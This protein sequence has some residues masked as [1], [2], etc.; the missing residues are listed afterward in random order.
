[1]IVS[2]ASNMFKTYCSEDQALPACL[3]ACLPPYLAFVNTFVRPQHGVKKLP[4]S[5]FFFP[6]RTIFFS[7]GMNEVFLWQVLFHSSPLFLGTLPSLPFPSAD[8]VDSVLSVTI[9][10]QDPRGGALSPL[11][12][13]QRNGESGGHTQKRGEGAQN[14]FFAACRPSL[15]LARTNDKRTERL[16]DWPLSGLLWPCLRIHSPKRSVSVCLSTFGKW[17]ND[18]DFSIFPR[19]PKSSS[20]SSPKRSCT[21][22]AA[23]KAEM[24]PRRGGRR[25]RKEGRRKA[26]NGIGEVSF[27]FVGS[28]R[29]LN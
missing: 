22:A 24:D 12:D 8:R 2:K 25:R 4:N 3:P 15:H 20:S 1:M 16:T 18:A 5:F 11:Q 7:P 27:G 19:M 29:E 23:A 21:T 17:L 6:S 10:R 14:S 9:I 28:S 26:D 13:R